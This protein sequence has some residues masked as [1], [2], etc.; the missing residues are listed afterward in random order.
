LSPPA[1][2]VVIPAYNRAAS[3]GTAIDSIL[4]QDFP[5]F[6]LV[7]VDDCSTDDTVAIVEASADPR[8]R[9]L[10]QP[11]N[12][13]PSAARNRGVREARGSLISFLDSDDRFLPHKLGFVARYFENNPDIDVLLDSFEVEYPRVLIRPRRAARANPD[14]QDSGAIER[15]VFARRVYK[16]TP[17]LTA[18]RLTL[19]DAG[20]FDEALRRREDMDLV[21]RLTRTSRC[22]TTS[23]IL[24]TKV[25]T[26]GTLSAQRETFIPTVIE[27]C[28][29]HPRYL[30]DPGL[31]P[32]L[33]R[34]EAR[35]L[36]RR[37]A[38]GQFRR[39][40]RDLRRLE[41]TQGTAATRALLAQGI[42]EILRRAWRGK[43]ALTRTPAAGA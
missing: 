6:E 30:T 11:S 38:R 22:A 10:R 7:V 29:R 43:P 17:A 37:L 40:V 35:H 19:I 2:S 18:R 25:W 33:A 28:R 5:D 12:G 31:R 14:S 26:R 8:V 23:A 9:C 34:D 41:E 15:A 13:G 1:I 36:L 24:W 20:L 27:I 21:V 39:A 16:A 4:A 3:I 32:G 42:G